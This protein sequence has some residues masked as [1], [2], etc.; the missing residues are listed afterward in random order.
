MEEGTSSL[1]VLDPTDEYSYLL[2]CSSTLQEHVW[3]HSHNNQEERVFL[4]DFEQ[5]FE[6]GDVEMTS[7]N[8]ME[9]VRGDGS[10]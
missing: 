4:H 8:D 7:G 10:R 1:S 6:E 9:I 5:M 2:P 3:K